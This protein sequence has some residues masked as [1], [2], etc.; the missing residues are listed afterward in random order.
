[1]NK[2]LFSSNK[3][4]WETPLELFEKLDQEFNFT[5]DVC[6]DSNNNKCKRYYS[7][8]QN[9]LLKDWTNEVVWCNPPYGR[10]IRRM[11]KKSSRK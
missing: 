8:E 10:K 2:V 3:E 7:K 5:I 1:M 6:A 9:G 11:G 4:N